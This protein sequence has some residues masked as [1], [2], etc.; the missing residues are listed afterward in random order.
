VVELRGDGAV[1]LEY[2][3]GLLG[4]VGERRVA[5]PEVVDRQTHAVARELFEAP[6]R[7]SGIAH[8]HGF[9]DL[10]F[11]VAKQMDR[12]LRAPNR[13]FRQGFGF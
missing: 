8:E 7:A 1:D 5:R 2:P 3:P 6:T 11:R 9:G 12:T 13:L 4:Q 10:K